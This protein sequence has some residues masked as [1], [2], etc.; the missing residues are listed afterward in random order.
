VVWLFEELGLAYELVQFKLGAP[1]MRSPDYLKVHP[2]GRVPVLEDGGQIIFESGAIIQYVVAKYG[3]GA[4]VPDIA[5]P[6]FGNYLQWLHFAE[7]MLMPQVN[8]L[9]VETVF[10][11]E[12]RR[13]QVNIDRAMKLLN[14]M[15]VAVDVHMEGRDYLAGQFSAADIM[16]GH[17]CSVSRRLGADISGLPNLSAYIDRI[18]TRPALIAARSHSD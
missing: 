14:R 10:L 6:E 4:L 12:E 8:I 2:M 15:L 18:E 17:A 9:V 11:S 1:E 7:G 3:D 13:N 5:S 16:T